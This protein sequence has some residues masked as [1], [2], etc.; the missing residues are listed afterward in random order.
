MSNSKTEQFALADVIFATALIM[1]P[2]PLAMVALVSNLS[3]LFSSFSGS[4]AISIELPN[5]SLLGIVV[6]PGTEGTPS[7]ESSKFISP[8]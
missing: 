3:D 2:T 4:F 1:F 8:V 5:S 7:S 6:N